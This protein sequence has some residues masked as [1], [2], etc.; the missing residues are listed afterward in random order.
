MGSVWTPLT[1]K[2]KPWK[3]VCVI[4][5]DWGSCILVEMYF[6]I[7]FLILKGFRG[8]SILKLFEVL[9][10]Y[11]QWHFTNDREKSKLVLSYFFCGG[12]RKCIIYCMGNQGN[13][14]TYLDINELWR[15]SII[16]RMSIFGISKYTWDVEN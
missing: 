12:G 2:E 10:L 15:F 6:I 11:F 7:S 13:G 4:H 1:L 14:F 5:W 3:P 8:S 9:L 16:K